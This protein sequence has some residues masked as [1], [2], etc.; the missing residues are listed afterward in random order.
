M[1][2]DLL[3]MIRIS[4]NASLD[5]VIT[6]FQQ[7]E[8]ILYRRAKGERLKKQLKQASSSNVETSLRKRYNEDYT[9]R[10]TA[11]PNKEKLSNNYTRKTKDHQVSEVTPSYYQHNRYRTTVEQNMAQPSESYGNHCYKCGGY[12]HWARDCSMQCGTYRQERNNSNSKNVSGALDER[13]SH[14]PM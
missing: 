2:N 3:N 6:E 8:D 9:R 13:T 4:R 1:R 14:A 5:E 10:T 12:G 11:W 7:I